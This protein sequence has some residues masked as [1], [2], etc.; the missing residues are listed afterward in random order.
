MP[1][2]ICATCGQHSYIPTPVA[3]ID[4]CP[5]CSGPVTLS[6][7]FAAGRARLRNHT[8]VIEDF[9]HDLLGRRQPD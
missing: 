5:N 4:E 1:Y 2:A 6:S 8:A 7:R 3:T 9:V